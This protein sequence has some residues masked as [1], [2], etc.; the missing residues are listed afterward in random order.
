MRPSIL[1]QA[2]VNIAERAVALRWSPGSSS[3]KQ[4]WHNVILSFHL[5]DIYF[6]YKIRY[7]RI[8]SNFFSLYLLCVRWWEKYKKVKSLED[9]AEWLYYER[10]LQ[11]LS[12]T[13]SKRGIR[14]FFISLR[15]HFFCLQTWSH[16]YFLCLNCIWVMPFNDKTNFVLWNTSTFSHKANV[17]KMSPGWY[18]VGIEEHGN[19]GPEDGLKKSIGVASKIKEVTCTTSSNPALLSFCLRHFVTLK[20][21][22]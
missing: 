16:F 2:E 21:P 3:R 10:D 14:I 9:L 19:K 8:K 5:G 4:L 22:L 20:S 7:F 11:I 1:W 13:Q 18:I 6:L 15:Q 17:W 12:H